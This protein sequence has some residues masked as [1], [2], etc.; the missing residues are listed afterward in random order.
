M[1]HILSLAL[2]CF[3]YV[4]LT[5]ALP[6]G[7]HD[8]N[9]QLDTSRAIEALQDQYQS[10]KTG[11]TSYNDPALIFHHEACGHICLLNAMQTLLVA[12]GKPTL[13][14]PAAL[15]TEIQNDHGQFIGGLSADR[16][17]KLMNLLLEKI[18]PA[19]SYA[20]DYRALEGTAEAL[21]PGLI[22]T[23]TFDLNQLRLARNAVKVISFIAVDQEGKQVGSHALLLKSFTDGLFLAAIDPNSPEHTLYFVVKPVILND[24]RLSVQMTP[25][26]RELM[27]SAYGSDYAVF[28]AGVGTMTL[29]DLSQTK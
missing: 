19:N 2:K 24:D 5:A 13:E 17:T 7:A 14:N 20:A 25:L 26:T 21:T 23:K 11:W 6:A 29:T 10:Q 9:S 28:L 27:N 22:I 3:A 16:F 15:L 1:P 4:L 18:L 12:I 8:C